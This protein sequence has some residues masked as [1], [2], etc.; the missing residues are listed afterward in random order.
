[1]DSTATPVS[2][3]IAFTPPEGYAFGYMLTREAYYWNDATF[4][5][6]KNVA[7]VGLYSI[8]NHGGCKWEFA[9][10]QENQSGLPLRVKVFD[11]AWAAFAAVPEFFTAL[12]SHTKGSGNASDLTEVVEILDG[13][14][15]L[16]LTERT[17]GIRGK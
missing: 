14:G 15:F 12:A 1:M 17:K 16:D 7:M 5:N 11:D 2:T 6:D 9:I 4:P 10:D 3:Q 13:L 8:D